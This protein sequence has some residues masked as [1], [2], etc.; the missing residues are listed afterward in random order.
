MNCYFCHE[1]LT[2][3]DF[4]LCKVVRHAHKVELFAH[5]KCVNEEY[6]GAAEEL[7]NNENS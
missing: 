1:P 6:L 7:E 4:K 2:S 5:Q 3:D